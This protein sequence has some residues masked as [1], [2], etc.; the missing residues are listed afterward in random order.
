MRQCSSC[1]F[2]NAPDA[3]FCDQCGAYFAI[4]K[5][6]ET[7]G[8]S[9]V[10]SSFAILVGADP[11]CGIRLSMDSVSGFHCLVIYDEA[12][13]VIVDLASSNGIYID[14][15]RVSRGE[16]VPVNSKSILQIGTEILDWQQV[17][18]FRNQALSAI[19]LGRNPNSHISIDSDAVSWNHGCLLISE[20]N[21]FLVDFAS[22][23]G[24][25]V[26]R[27]K[28]EHKKI[29]RIE[30]IG[31]QDEILIGGNFY[32]TKYLFKLGEDSISPQ[33]ID[34][35]RI[36]RITTIGR[37]SECEV[38]VPYQ[39][40]SNIHARLIV[41]S[42]GRL[43]IEDLKSL[44]GT[45]I[46]GK[47]V[48]GKVQIPQG[49]KV[50]IASYS[51]ELKFIEGGISAEQRN[52]VFKLDVWNIVSTVR[53]RRTLAERTI[54][55]DVS[56]KV[57]PGKLVAFMGPSGAGKTS[58]L[59][60]INGYERP[61][62]GKILI[63]DD[64]LYEHYDRYRCLIGYVPQDDILHPE[65]TVFEALCLS[66][67]LRLPSDTEE[68]ELKKHVQA[69]IDELNL[70][71]IAHEQIGSVDKKILSGGQRK[72]VN[73][74]IELVSDPLILFLDE[75]TSGLS[76]RDTMD[77]VLSLKKLAQKGRTIIMTIHQPSQEA[78]ELIDEV[79]YLA[80]GGKQAYYGATSDSFSYFGVP[81][82]SPDKIMDILSGNHPMDL[83]KQFSLS[84]Q[85]N[86]LMQMRP[87][88]T[89][90]NQESSSNGHGDFKRATFRSQF[91]ILFLRYFL[92]KYRDHFS[93]FFIAIQSPLVAFLLAVLF[94][95][96]K[97]DILE[98][99]IPLFVLGIAIVFFGAFNSC[100]EL[101]RERAIFKREQMVS[102]R[103]ESYL[104][105]KFAFLSL[106]GLI[107]VV[108]MISIVH[109][110]LGL[111]G[112]WIQYCGLLWIANMSAVAMGLLISSLV[113][114]SE[115]AMG[116]V[117]IV[118][119]F[120]IILGGFLK[121][122]K[123]NQINFLST[124]FISRWTTEGLMEIEREGILNLTTA[125]SKRQFEN[126]EQSKSYRPSDKAD[127]FY[128]Q[129]SYANDPAKID[130]I[131]NQSKLEAWK[132]QYQ[133]Q[134][135]LSTEKLYFDF[136]MIALIGITF[137]SLTWIRIRSSHTLKKRR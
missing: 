38:V 36:I 127:R 126:I 59:M 17:M 49:A 64:E 109:V 115:A 72:R 7:V 2:I 41:Y 102:L 119:I 40:V 101:V 89:D 107:Q 50:S 85:F 122:L 73:L 18:K 97:S 16:F 53:D 105:S 33:S 51:I 20:K 12:S 46:D 131:Q 3:K 78:Y 1:Q 28:G 83:Q 113:R 42:D 82:G 8:S 87:D 55:D 114:S 32:T 30:E 117:P 25:Y 31:L 65:L 48:R 29:H 129:G 60:A 128:L 26:K 35:A 125:V 103:A 88:D 121:P 95:D 80:K 96:S 24:T 23:N 110:A 90:F 134:K 58:L 136:I 69:V 71:D 10:D 116:I 22:V 6:R 84:R 108:I 104:C 21:Y 44:N 98:R 76:S 57:E 94:R 133:T 56:F 9:N 62:Q 99:G 132:F 47:M 19:M 68:S 106:V 37:S 14:S 120:Q 45:F 111:E 52:Q 92:T 100:R 4:W 43:F 123:D 54:I 15:R 75:P 130:K 77:V 86:K 67:C 66:A 91:K 79:L 13:F 34:S 124:P 74:A 61:K 112:S 63:N 11:R 135:G 27:S 137:L 81:R 5:N 93:I 118:I 39:Q 70:T